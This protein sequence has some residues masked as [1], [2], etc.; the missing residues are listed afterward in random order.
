MG[1]F[2]VYCNE[3]GSGSPRFVER[4]PYSIINLWP[5]YFRCFIFL[6]PLFFMKKSMIPQLLHD[7]PPFS[8]K[9]NSPLLCKINYQ[10]T[11]CDQVFHYVKYFWS[12]KGKFKILSR[13][14]IVGGF[15]SKEQI[16][17][18]PPIFVWK[19]EN[20]SENGANFRQ[21]LLFLYEFDSKFGW[22]GTWTGPF[23]LES[24]YLHGWCFKFPSGTSLPKPKL[25]TPGRVKFMDVTSLT[26]DFKWSSYFQ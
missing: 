15:E 8:V 9:N 19:M 23:F 26:I 10:L 25:S 13:S 12:S 20:L 14:K 2:S 11:T 6:T 17:E 24:W 16:W 5:P 21:N 22:F 1:S 3:K 4:K 7:P 18:F